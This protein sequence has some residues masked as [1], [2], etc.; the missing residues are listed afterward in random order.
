MD[1]D[2]EFSAEERLTYSAVCPVC[3]ETAYP[4]WQRV[5]AESAPGTAEKWKLAL[6]E[7]LTPGCA[8]S[9]FYA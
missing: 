2:R 8:D 9:R 6:L 3:G 4:T 5:Y 7:C 1:G